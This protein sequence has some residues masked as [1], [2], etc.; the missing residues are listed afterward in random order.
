MKKFITVSSIVLPLPEENIDTDQLYPTRF[1]KESGIVN[2]GDVLLYDWRFDE[3]GKEKPSVFN[4]PHYKKA[5]ILLTGDG[6]GIGSSRENAVWALRDYGI[7]CIMGTTFGDIFANNCF[8]NGILVIKFSPKEIEQIKV[9]IEKNQFVL[10]SVDLK[11]Q[12]V[13]LSD[14]S[15]IEFTIDPFQK[16]CLLNGVD[17]I[18]YILKQKKAIQQ[19]ELTYRL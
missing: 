4:D 11:K 18:G 19:Y 12:W 15:I 17:E 8:K 14:K 1:V 7:R 6:F 2:H 3:N 13:I 9:L 10:V 16:T 5:Q